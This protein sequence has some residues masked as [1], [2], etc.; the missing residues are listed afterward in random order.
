M[1]GYWQDQAA[2]EQAVD[3]D[4]WLHTGDIATMN[5][6]GF[7]R[8]TDRK[9]DMFIAGGFNAYPAEI[10]RMLLQHRDIAEV[11]VGG[12]PD[13][14]LGGVAAAFVVPRE[15]RVPD[16]GELTAWARER[17]ANFKVPR[18]IVLVDELPRNA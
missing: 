13:A 17:M 14:G 9:K 10:E 6:R 1:R 12:V 2:T 18:H 5:E 11:A 4:G 8:I 16:P 15:G 7:L 3:A